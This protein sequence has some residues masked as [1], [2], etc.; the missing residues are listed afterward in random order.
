MSISGSPSSSGPGPRPFTAVA[1]V[2]IPLGI[3]RKGLTQGPV[4]QL[5]S[6]PPCHGGGRRFESGRGRLILACRTQLH[7][8]P[9]SSVGT[10]VRLKIGRSAVRPRPWPPRA[11][12]PR[13]ARDPGYCSGPPAFPQVSDPAKAS[14]T[15]FGPSA[16][17]VG[18]GGAV[19]PSASD[20]AG[21]VTDWSR[22]F[23]VSISA[24]SWIVSA[25]PRAGTP[26][27]EPHT[28]RST[29]GQPPTKF[30]RSRYS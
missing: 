23:C 26:R 8:R 22:R 27:A 10:S 30:N 24:F 13:T 3:R 19:E 18:A 6:A 29:T 1:R 28:A 12:E 15:S 5:V 9:G 16:L 20:G 21:L 11:D 25:R 7:A 17:T 14:R 4:A 2:R